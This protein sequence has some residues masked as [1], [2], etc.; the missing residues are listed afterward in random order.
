MK[1]GSSLSRCIPDI[2]NGKVPLDEV[3]LLVTR[4]AFPF[5]QGIRN[6]IDDIVSYHSGYLEW[7]G[8]DLVKCADVLF[9]L[10]D[11]GRVYQPR[12]G[13]PNRENQGHNFVSGPTWWDLSPGPKESH[14][15][16]Q[17]AWDQYQ[18]AL[19]LSGLRPQW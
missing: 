15:M 4:T 2:V 19:A 8:L 14:P 16:V 10:L 12:I 18:T 5:E 11:T 17:D 1:I 6:M 3:A 9:T 7:Q 13:V